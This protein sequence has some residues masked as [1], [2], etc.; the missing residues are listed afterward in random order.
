M[1]Q[2]APFPIWWLYGSTGSP[3]LGGGVATA[4]GLY[5]IGASMDKYFRAFDVESGAV[6]WE[7]RLPYFA[8]A[9]PMTYR[10]RPSGRQYVVVAAGGNPLGEMGDALVAYALP[11]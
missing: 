10:L 6:L 7:T 3:N 5:F 9:V 8:N 2:S 1:T 11:D 4:S